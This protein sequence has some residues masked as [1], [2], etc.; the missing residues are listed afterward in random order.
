MK[1]AYSLV[2]DTK[3]DTVDGIYFASEL[4]KY[5]DKAYYLDQLI[6]EGEVK[7]DEENGYDKK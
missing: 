7:E 2:I 4:A 1:L 5:I 6:Y 3:E